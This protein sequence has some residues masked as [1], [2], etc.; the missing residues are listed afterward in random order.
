MIN[1]KTINSAKRQFTTV[2]FLL[3]GIT[4]TWKWLLCHNLHAPQALVSRVSLV[5]SSVKYRTFGPQMLLQIWC[6]MFSWEI[7]V[8]KVSRQRALHWVLGVGQEVAVKRPAEGEEIQG[9]AALLLSRGADW[10]AWL[11]YATLWA[12]LWQKQPTHQLPQGLEARQL[13]QH[14]DDKITFVKR[15]HFMHCLCFWDKVA[16]FLKI[17]KQQQ[18]NVVDLFTWYCRRSVAASLWSAMDSQIFGNEV[19]L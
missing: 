2:W 12:A 16:Q 14:L 7:R 9:L 15:S 8:E 3:R 10:A 6:E 19:R 18:E 11:E 5:S 4:K 17:I 1:S 13:Y